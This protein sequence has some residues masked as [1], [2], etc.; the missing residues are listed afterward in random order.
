[1]SKKRTHNT[2]KVTFNKQRNKFLATYSYLCP[3]TGT[4]KSKSF[5]HEKRKSAEDL[6]TN[7]RKDFENGLYQQATNQ[8]VK[9]Y[10]TQWLD[11]H[12]ISLEEKSKEKCRSTVNQYL[13]Q[14]LGSLKLTEL[15]STNL[16]A[17]FNKLS[18]SGRRDGKPLSGYTLRNALVYLKKSLSDA[19]EQG[20]LMKNP[21]K[22]IKL[23]PIKKVEFTVLTEDECCE[24]I[25]LAKNSGIPLL[26]LLI[27]LAIST[28]LRRGEI[29][30]LQWGDIDFTNHEI[31]VRRSV[32]TTG[33]K[34]IIKSPKTS[35]S[36]RKIPINS[37][38][39]VALKEYQD[40]QKEI[41]KFFQ[42]IKHSDFI[43]TKDDGSLYHP[44][45][46]IANYF[47]KILLSQ[48]NFPKKPRF[49]DLRH[50]CATLLLANNTSHKIVQE[51]LGHSKSSTTLDTY[52]HV[53]PN[54]QKEAIQIFD[55]LIS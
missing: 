22:N 12:T 20:F 51:R 8:T 41:Q 44:G 26:Y 48:M 25:S 13:I 3:Y 50:T 18:Q 40:Q 43:F 37:D 46:F 11:H 30:G 28:G 55:K 16:Q 14:H 21:A 6:M 35:S 5:S 7:W 49:H 36:N 19:V 15:T 32:V 29:F 54:M 45:Y 38:I 52:S 24:I 34:L 9:D 23:P 39:V 47:T 4:K 17:L 31:L 33:T 10:L 2:G 53:T 27:L 1:M 42:P